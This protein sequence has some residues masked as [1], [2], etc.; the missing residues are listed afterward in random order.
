M[1][2]N[3]TILG[4]GSAV[5]NQNRNST[6]QI[7]ET[8]DKS[9]LI[10]CADGTQLQFMRYGAHTSRISHIF[11]SHL[12]G[13]H[14]FGLVPLL[15][16]MGMKNHN[17]DVHIHSHPDLEQLLK[18]LLD[19]FCHDMSFH[20]YFEPF[21]PLE[22]SLIY[23]DR[24]IT[25]HTI[26]LVH[27]LPTA[28]FLFKE[29]AFENPNSYAYCSDTRY[30]ERILPIIDGVKCLYHETTYGSEMEDKAK[31]RLHSTTTDAAKIAEQAHAGKLI[32]GHF[33]KR[34]D[35]TAPLLQEARAIFPN[36]YTAYDGM[37]ERW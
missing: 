11:I 24:S 34:Y 9:F 4:S 30:T 26:P 22:S 19:Y 21:N 6:A 37:K 8:H 29:K 33:S 28:G 7:L 17:K 14:F 31:A 13:D 16:T 2:F 10:D 18:P 12:H 32:I 27:S 36:T 5:P 1:D 3:L 23:E 35:D 20:I 15:T 25:V